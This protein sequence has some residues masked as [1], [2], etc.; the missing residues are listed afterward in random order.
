MDDILIATDDDITHHWQIIHEVLDKLEKESY[1]LRLTKCESEK[2]RV[3]YLGDVISRERI[4]I[5][6]IKLKGLQNWP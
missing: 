5:D 2:D 1:F 6:P 3:D 4:H